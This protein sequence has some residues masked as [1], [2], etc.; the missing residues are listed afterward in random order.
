MYPDENTPAASKVAKPKK[1]TKKVAEKKAVEKK[2]ADVAAEKKQKR[3][4]AEKLPYNFRTR[5]LA[6]ALINA[7]DGEDE[8]KEARKA[9]KE[10]RTF[11]ETRT[12]ALTLVSKADFEAL[13]EAWFDA[14]EEKSK[15]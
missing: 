6:R 10:A 2:T 11:E 1:P 7:V 12:A 5:S 14:G 8:K 3:A 15:D 9:L 4:S 13:V